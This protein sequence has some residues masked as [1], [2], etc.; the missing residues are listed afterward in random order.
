MAGHDAPSTDPVAAAFARLEVAM[1]V[2][3]AIPPEAQQQPLT[4]SIR[5]AL[6]TCNWLRALGLLLVLALSSYALLNL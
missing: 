1:H 2:A 4:R 3:I 5:L 6:T